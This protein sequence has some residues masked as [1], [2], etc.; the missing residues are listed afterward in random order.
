RQPRR[1]HRLPRAGGPASAPIPG[2]LP[3]RGQSS[4]PPGPAGGCPQRSTYRFEPWA[5]SAL[6]RPLPYTRFDKRGR[7]LYPQPNNQLLGELMRHLI[8]L[9]VS[10]II[11][12]ALACGTAATPPSQQP[13]DTGPHY[14]GKVTISVAT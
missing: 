2:I 7:L 9:P 3:G 12:A 5:S 14:G 8:L 11:L 6:F 13:A 4:S 1:W 10:A